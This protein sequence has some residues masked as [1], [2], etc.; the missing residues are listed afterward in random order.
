MHCGMSSFGFDTQRIIPV[1]MAI[2]SYWTGTMFQEFTGVNSFHSHTLWGRGH[3]YYPGCWDGS[4]SA[5][6]PSSP[7]PRLTG[8]MGMNCF[9]LLLGPPASG[10]V[11]P[12]GYMAG[13]Q[14]LSPGLPPCWGCCRS[15]TSHSPKPQPQSEALSTQLSLQL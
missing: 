1:L 11:P 13:D 3:L 5:P 10:W 15:A 14:S 9:H 6:L 2:N 4:R 12:M 8:L 7:C